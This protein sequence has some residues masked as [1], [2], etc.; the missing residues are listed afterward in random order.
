MPCIGPK[1]QSMSPEVPAPDSI[2][3]VNNP[4]PEPGDPKPK[5]PPAPDDE[6]KG[7]VPVDLPGKPRAPERV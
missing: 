7:I 1:A 5:A 3:P 6:G 4:D 2:P